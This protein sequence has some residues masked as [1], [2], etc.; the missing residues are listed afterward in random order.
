MRIGKQRNVGADIIKI[1]AAIYVIFIHH[2]VKETLAFQTEYH[3]LYAGFFLISMLIGAGLFCYGKKHDWSNQKSLWTTVA[4]LLFVLS[5]L[6]LSKFAVSF[7]LMISGFMLASTMEKYPSRELDWY[8]KEN[9]IP[10]ILRFFLPLIPVVIAGL[11]IHIVI[12][13]KP[14]DWLRVIKRFLLGGFAPGSYYI[15]VMIQILLLF[16]LLYKA[17]ARW[18]EKGVLLILALTLVWDILATGLLS[19]SE[20]TYK[21]CAIRL[22]PQ[23]ALGIYAKVTELKHRSPFCIGLF[24]IGLIYVLIFVYL[25]ALPL[26]LFYQWRSASLFVALFLYPIVTGCLAAFQTIHYPQSGRASETMILLSNATYH[27]FLIQMFYYNMIGYSWNEKANH[28]LLTMPVNLIVCM[29]GGVLYYKLSSPLEAKLLKKIKQ[30]LSK[31][32]SC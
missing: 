18:K 28:I 26:P 14:Y 23:V 20:D 25:K 32:Q 13:D 30:K 8:R 9:L 3:L 15:V 5:L 19:L 17:V 12:Q 10:R 24:F 11:F 27:I 1:A 4:P 31:N 2:K 29:A 22:L 7:F 21:F 16:P 6:L